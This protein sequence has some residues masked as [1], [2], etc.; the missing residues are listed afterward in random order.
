MQAGVNW[1][2]PAIIRR[3]VL[4]SGVPVRYT[5]TR[6]E[7]NGVYKGSDEPSADG[8]LPAEHAV[9]ERKLERG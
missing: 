6:T 7:G 2:H 9:S 1:E 3:L 8:V 5:D 4:N